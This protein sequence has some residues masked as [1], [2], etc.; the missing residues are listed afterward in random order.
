MMME[1]K[2]GFR[3]EMGPSGVMMEIVGMGLGT[4]M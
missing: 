2:I 1:I 4:E 3:M